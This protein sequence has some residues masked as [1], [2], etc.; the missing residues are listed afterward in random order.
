MNSTQRNKEC[1][2]ANAFIILAVS[3]KL[4]IVNAKRK[5]IVGYCF[6][7]GQNSQLNYLS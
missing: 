1:L 2:D 6:S 3:G 5:S 7:R 4:T